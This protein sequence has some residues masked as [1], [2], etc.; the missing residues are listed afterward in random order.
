MI[1]RVPSPRLLVRSRGEIYAIA[2][3]T[4]RRKRGL[5]RRPARSSLD[6]K[7]RQQLGVRERRD[8][9]ISIEPAEKYFIP[10]AVPLRH[11]LGE[12]MYAASP[13]PA[14]TIASLKFRFDGNA[15]KTS[16]S[17]SIFFFG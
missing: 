11:E 16:I 9:F 7:S 15:R 4:G 10:A 2:T 14:I 5:R 6:E 8:S 1:E 3:T 17:S 13:S 12:S